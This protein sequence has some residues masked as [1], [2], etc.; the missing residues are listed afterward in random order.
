MQTICGRIFGENFYHPSD[1]EHYKENILENEDTV[2]PRLSDTWLID[3][4][5]DQNNTFFFLL[6]L[7]EEYSIKRNQ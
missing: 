2:E 3:K 4:L 6:N 1:N 7:L 5:L